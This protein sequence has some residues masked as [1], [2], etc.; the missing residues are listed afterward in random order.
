MWLRISIEEV[1]LRGL[2]HVSYQPPHEGRRQKEPPIVLGGYH[3]PEHAGAYRPSTKFEIATEERHVQLNMAGIVKAYPAGPTIPHDLRI[4]GVER[5]D[6]CLTLV[7]EE[8]F[9]RVG[10]V[11]RIGA[12]NREHWM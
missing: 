11:E 1:Q 9:E 5:R 2:R 10:I 12:L 8:R 3:V 4:R 7:R 6:K